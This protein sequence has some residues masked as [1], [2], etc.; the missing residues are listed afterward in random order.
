MYTGLL[1]IVAYIFWGIPALLTGVV[2]P[3]L[4]ACW[5]SHLAVGAIGA[6]LSGIPLLIIDLPGRM[7]GSEGM[8]LLIAMLLGMLASTALSWLTKQV[9]SC[10]GDQPV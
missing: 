2:S 4:R 10:S 5:V 1:Y 8:V 3:W 7:R 6:V 9:L